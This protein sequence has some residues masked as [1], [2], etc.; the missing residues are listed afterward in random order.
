MRGGSFL[1]CPLAAVTVRPH[2]DGELTAWDRRGVLRSVT[3]TDVR[4]WRRVHMDLLRYAGCVCR[5]SC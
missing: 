4:L 2:S 5:P 1:A 3:D